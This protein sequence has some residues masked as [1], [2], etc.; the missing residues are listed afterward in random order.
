M[1]PK[2]MKKISIL[3]TLWNL[4]NFASTIFAENHNVSLARSTV[5]CSLVI[6]FAKDRT[7]KNY[8]DFCGPSSK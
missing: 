2:F 4:F 8:E 3:C 5:A 1:Q 7:L 6:T